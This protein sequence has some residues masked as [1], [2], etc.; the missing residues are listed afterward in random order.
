MAA[1]AR[2]RI[3]LID[4][5]RVSRFTTQSLLE[6]LG[7]D[8]ETLDDG[9]TAAE[10]EA[11]GRYAAVIM[12]CQMPF[13]DGFEATAAIRRHQRQIQGRRTPIIGLSARSMAGDEDV[14]LS[15][16]MDVYLTKPV[17]ARKLQAALDDVARKAGAER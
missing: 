15:K 14:A 17:S 13:V 2:P 5:E 6:R 12:D 3:L 4:D 7:F 9:R 16:G 11:T 1:N 10:A 8:V